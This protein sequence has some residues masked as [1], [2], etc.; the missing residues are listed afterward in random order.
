MFDKLS[1]AL[2]LAVEYITK[3]DSY[4]QARK[5]EQEE[6]DEREAWRANKMNDYALNCRQCKKL[7]Y[8]ISGTLNRYRCSCG[9][10]FSG[11]KHSL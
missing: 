11:A 8:P 5:K 2:G 10:Q 7:A 3:K 1:V 9:N 4:D 6:Q